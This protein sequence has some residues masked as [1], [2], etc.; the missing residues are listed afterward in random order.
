MNKSEGS[1]RGRLVDHQKDGSLVKIRIVRTLFGMDL[2]LVDDNRV[3]GAEDL[4]IMKDLEE[5]ALSLKNKKALR[6]D[7]KALFKILCKRKPY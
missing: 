3:E 2:S 1:R 4:F 7:S 6:P 5:A